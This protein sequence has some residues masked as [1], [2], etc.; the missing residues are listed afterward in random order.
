MN[1]LSRQGLTIRLLFRALLAAV[2]AS[3]LGAGVCSAQ[4]KLLGRHLLE[5]KNAHWQI[6]A[7]K[8]TYVHEKRLYVAE[9]NV[10]ITRNGQTLSAQRGVYNEETG[11][12]QVYG[13]VRLTANGDIVSGEMALLDLTNHFG[14]ITNGT[15]YLRE[16]NYYI[17]GSAMVRTGANTYHVKN[18]RIT[19]CDGDDP[20]WSITGSEVNVTVEGYGSVKNA[21]FRIKGFPIFYLPFAV[22]PVKTK[23]QTGFL[24][25]RLGYS[26]QNGADLEVPFFWA[27][28][29]QVDATF[30]ERYMTERG[31]MQGLELRYVAANDSRGTFLFDILRDNVE[32]KDMRD[33]EYV[34]LS[35]SDRT[36]QTRYWFRSRMDQTLFP[37]IEA[38]LDTDYVSDQDYLKEFQGGLTGFDARPELS[39]YGRP[40]EDVRS[41][42]RRN[43]LRLSADRDEFSLQG[44][45]AYHQ[46][47]ENPAL[48][49]TAQ[50]LAGAHFSLLPRPLP[51]MPFFLT[52]DTDYGYIWRDYG[53][54]G[55]RFV[56]DPEVSYPLFLGRYLE[57]ETS[58]AYTYNAQWVDDDPLGIDRQTRNAYHAQARLSTVL[59]R[60]FDIQWREYTGLK[61]KIRP[62]LTY[63]FRSHRDEDR[64]QPWFEPIDDVGDLNHVTL[65]I[66]NILDSRRDDEEGKTHYA[67]WGTFTLRQPYSIDEARRD[68]EPE[69]DREPFE[70]LE[71][72]L[73]VFP[74]PWLDV[75]AE[76]HW[77]HYQ[78]DITYT[79]ISAGFSMERSGGRTDRYALEYQYEEDDSQFL[80]YRVH[81]NLAGGFSAG[82]ALRKELEMDHTLDSAYWVQYQAQ[83]WGLRLSAGS[84]DGVDSFM[85]TFHLL[86]LGDVGDQ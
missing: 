41:P 47:P 73:N 70:P 59:E 85:L 26:D 9:G 2:L 58:I 3:V 16:N 61:H 62:T 34:E 43:A 5:D 50:P 68:D 55:H 56:L 31:F 30:Y 64:F 53:V 69:R 36:N 29:D 6:T 74:F 44:L 82:T 81:L 84:L 20:A 65:A 48:D 32:E 67:Q 18:C 76:T 15:I 66:E 12:V 57:F 71:A 37:G 42:T 45:A 40:V 38:R 8:M 49:D 22:F 39:E 25:P 79:D 52:L 78:S 72:E 23:R 77:D 1:L 11:I 7:D 86:G 60:T 4:E 24:P 83:C 27:I 80:G 33:P 21:A 14:Q 46:R 13:D 10:M 35:P 75:D 28:S 63:D 17:R 54:K 19:T 51:H